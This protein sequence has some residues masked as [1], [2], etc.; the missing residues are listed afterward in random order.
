VILGYDDRAAITKESLDVDVIGGELLPLIHSEFHDRACL[1][2][3]KQG[4]PLSFRGIAGAYHQLPDRAGLAP[5]SLEGGWMA[6]YRGQVIPPGASRYRFWG[7]ADNHLLLAINGKPVFEGSRNNSSFKELG[8]E[9]TD[10]P[11]LPCLIAPAGFACSEWIEVDSGPVRLD[12]LFGEVGGNITSGLLLVEREGETY[13]ETFW[14][15]PKWPLF[16]TETPS[17]EEA[18]EFERLVDHLEQKTMG[19][20][21]VSEEAV[22]KVA[23]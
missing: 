6:W 7:Y 3:L 4:E 11:A 13:E 22:W 5:Y 12:I 20:F 8:I 21:T 16:L 14:G 17:A 23:E 1:E 2:A 19:S 10:N 9:R 15:Q 18:A